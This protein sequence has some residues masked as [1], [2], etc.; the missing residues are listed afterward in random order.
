MLDGPIFRAVYD[1]L[2]VFLHC[3]AVYQRSRELDAG[4]FEVG[5]GAGDAV[6]RVRKVTSLP[7]DITLHHVE[8]GAR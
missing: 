4:L 7:T 5:A 1:R 6:Q 3:I 8:V 2:D